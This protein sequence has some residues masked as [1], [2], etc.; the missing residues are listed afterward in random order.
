M[1]DEISDVI[2]RTHQLMGGSLLDNGMQ[3]L[4]DNMRKQL[5]Q[6]EKQSLGQMLELEQSP[7]SIKKK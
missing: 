5:E 2:D 6:E 4:Q 1:S 7:K 3:Q